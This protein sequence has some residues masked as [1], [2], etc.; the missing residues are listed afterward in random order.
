[1]DDLDFIKSIIEGE[2]DNKE[3]NEEFE[4]INYEE[5]IYDDI[6]EEDFGE[7][8]D[9]NE[10]IK[11]NRNNLEYVEDEIDYEFEIDKPK[12]EG[13][14]DLIVEKKMRNLWKKL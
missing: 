13:N 8:V 2:K 14:L 9:E 1:M 10:V 6:I 4:E 7:K 5:E 3:Y 11:M 12:I